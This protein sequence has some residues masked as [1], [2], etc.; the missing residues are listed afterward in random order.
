MSA[1]AAGAGACGQASALAQPLALAWM[2]EGPG[3]A[4]SGRVPQIRAEF[5]RLP[6]FCN[7][8]YAMKRN[9]IYGQP[10]EGVSP[11]CRYLHLDDRACYDWLVTSPYAW[12]ARLSYRHWGVAASLD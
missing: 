12:A 5:G 6:S 7:I 9:N 1:Q 10:G 3:A 11:Y 4:N 2:D 8:N